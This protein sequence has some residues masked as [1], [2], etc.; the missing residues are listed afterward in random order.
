MSA[1]P[2]P[3]IDDINAPYWRAARERRFVLQRCRACK[4]WVYYPRAM[5]PGCWAGELE[6]V[7]GSGRARVITWT[8]VHQAPSEAFAAKVPYVLAVVRLEEGPQMMA[9]VLHVEPSEMRVDLPL[10]VVFEDRGGFVIPQ[11]E[12][13]AP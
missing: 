12:P 5:C 8:V 9:N 10:R 3:T 13:E 4:S 6:W 2:H 11:L 7:E 1:L